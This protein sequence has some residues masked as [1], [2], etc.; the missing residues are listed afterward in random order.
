MPVSF[1]ERLDGIFEIMKLTELMGHVRKHKRDR[2]ANGLLP[3]RDHSCDRHLPWLEQLLDFGE[4]GRQIS[5]R[6]AE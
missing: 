3:I 1:V 2:T 4:P 5:L 6:T